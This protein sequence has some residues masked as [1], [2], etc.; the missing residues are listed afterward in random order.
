MRGA[1]N[2]T[3]WP[4]PVDGKWKIEMLRWLGQ[5]TGIRTLVET[6]TCEG[7]TP[8]NLKDDFGEIHTIELHD[9]LHERAG[10]WLAPYPHV[11]LYHGSSKTLL[12]ELL[13]TDKV[14]PGPTLFWLDAH[15][16]GPHTADDGDP[17]PH[18][19]KA[20]TELE[21]FALVLVD[22]MMGLGQF[23]GQVSSV[24]LSDWNVEYRTGEILLHRKGFYSIPQF[25]A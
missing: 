8:F 21:P 22:D 19:L 2:F 18:E 3:Q 17:L 15:S 16:S 13:E 5:L 9:G 10:A 7:V 20:I 12:R 11:K 23:L 14:P 25:E 6:G 24:D 1:P 4:D